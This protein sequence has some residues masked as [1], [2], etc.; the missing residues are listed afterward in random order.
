M[1]QCRDFDSQHLFTKLCIT[2]LHFWN[3]EAKGSDNH[4]P[5]FLSN[6]TDQIL[7][8]Q[9]ITKPET[10]QTGESFSHFARH[11]PVATRQSQ[12]VVSG[13]V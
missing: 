4:K 9:L 5:R 12:E 13:H 3:E 7:V 6:K 1:S 8:P 2:E 10:D 11:S